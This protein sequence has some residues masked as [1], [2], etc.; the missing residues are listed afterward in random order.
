LKTLR[1]EGRNV[2]GAR[3]K[4]QADKN[5]EQNDMKAEIAEKHARVDVLAGVMVGPKSRVPATPTIV[6]CRL[7][8]L[9]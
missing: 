6:T 3:R 4:R 8:T 7:F 5:A 9:H 1:A 2:G